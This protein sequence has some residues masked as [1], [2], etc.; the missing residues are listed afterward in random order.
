MIKITTN[1]ICSQYKTKRGK[2]NMW[3]SI[4]KSFNFLKE[5]ILC[6]FYTLFHSNIVCEMKDNIIDNRMSKNS[7]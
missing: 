6:T 7:F 3:I 1:V 5:H 4:I 2:R